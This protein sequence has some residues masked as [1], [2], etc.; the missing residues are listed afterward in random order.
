MRRRPKVSLRHYVLLPMM[1]SAIN[2]RTKL[3]T[4]CSSVNALRVIV[5]AQRPLR[6]FHL[7]RNATYNGLQCR[8]K[9][10]VYLRQG[11]E[12]DLFLFTAIRSPQGSDCFHLWPESYRAPVPGTLSTGHMRT[13]AWVDCPTLLLI[14]LPQVHHRNL[15][16]GVYRG[17]LHTA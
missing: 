5:R 7:V 16:R 6:Q 12:T 10:H 9:V 1:C 17:N 2:L 8:E 4:V 15:R 3:P 11:T 14:V 13:V